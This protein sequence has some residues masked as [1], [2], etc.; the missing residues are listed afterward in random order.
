MERIFP[1]LLARGGHFRPN[2]AG[3]PPAFK[4][5]LKTHRAQRRMEKTFTH[6]RKSR[7]NLNGRL[8]KL[9]LAVVSGSGSKIKLP[10]NAARTATRAEMAGPITI[11]IQDHLA[12]VLRFGWRHQKAIR[13]IVPRG[14]IPLHQ[15][16]ILPLQ[17]WNP[18][19]DYKPTQQPASLHY[20]MH[21]DSPLA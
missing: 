20:L 3:S 14:T 15:D 5:S 19:V 11:L 16:L 8:G 21:N 4:M 18:L 13:G 9:R 10:R 2:L 6:L 17:A 1:P 7:E 12:I